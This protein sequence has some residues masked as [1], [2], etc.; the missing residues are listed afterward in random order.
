M[1]D[2]AGRSGRFCGCDEAR[3]VRGLRRGPP[4][5]HHRSAT[6]K[7]AVEPGPLDSVTIEPSDITLAVT[8][9]TQ[10]TSSAFDQFDNPVPGLTYSLTVDDPAGKV[11]GQ[12]AFVAATKPGTY[13]VFV[14]VVQG[15][16]TRSATAM[17]AVEP[18]PLDSVTIEPSDITLVVTEE[19]QFTSSAFDRFDNPVPGLTFDFHSKEQAGQVGSQGRF[20]AGTK[21][22]TFKNAVTVEVIQSGV[23]KT[24]AARV[25]VNSGPLHEVT[26]VPIEVS[27]GSQRQLDQLQR[28]SMATQ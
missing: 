17:I 22:G 19:T 5:D 15:A 27:A 14:E 4:G 12:G 26:V 2:A 20:T 7:I 11:D 16:I 3:H 10:F 9:E 18:G 8:E 21:A 28:T 13:E 24:A 25:T 1:D 23:T 6:A